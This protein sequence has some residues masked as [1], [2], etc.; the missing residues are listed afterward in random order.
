[1]SDKLTLF[2]ITLKDT[3]RVIN[4]DEIEYGHDLTNGK[5]YTILGIFADSD[6]VHPSVL[7]VDDVGEG[8]YILESEFAA[9]EFVKAVTE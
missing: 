8:T 5:E 4:H 1:M 7:V 9:V 3:L 6:E 2:D